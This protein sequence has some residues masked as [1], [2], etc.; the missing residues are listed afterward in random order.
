MKQ[1]MFIQNTPI[2]EKRIS[3]IE[4]VVSR[5][6]RRTH[7][8]TTA[9]IPPQVIMAYKSGEDIHGDIFK[10]ILFKGRLGKTILLFNEK[11]KSEIRIDIK[12]LSGDKGE[13]KTFYVSRIKSEVDLDIDTKDGTIISISIYSVD[14]K[15]K[16]TEV[17]I[18]TLWHPSVS[19]SKTEQ[20]LIDD[21]LGDDK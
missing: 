14:E 8:T 7:K 3:F 4:R 17:W 20:Y 5:L 16:V 11:P 2:D 15:Y 19:S 9:V 10:G 21:L 12:V 18:S 13:T 6:S 1:P